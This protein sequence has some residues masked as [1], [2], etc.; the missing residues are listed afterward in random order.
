MTKIECT[1]DVRV[2][3]SHNCFNYIFKKNNSDLNQIYD[4]IF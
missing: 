3:S 1:Y 4:T 2:W